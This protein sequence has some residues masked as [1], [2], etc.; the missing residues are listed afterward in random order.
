VVDGGCAAIQHVPEFG[1]VAMESVHLR[2]YDGIAC[3]DCLLAPLNY[4]R[5]VVL[6]EGLA[7]G[8]L[9]LYPRPISATVLMTLVITSMLTIL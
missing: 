9:F 8:E 6:V 7:L 5:D 1:M 3:R 2:L 4:H